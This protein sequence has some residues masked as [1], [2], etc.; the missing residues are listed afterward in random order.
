[1]LDK[2]SAVDSGFLG[3][4]ISALI[5]GLGG[6][7]DRLAERARGPAEFAGGMAGGDVVLDAEHLGAEFRLAA[8]RGRDPQDP[9]PAAAGW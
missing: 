2:P 5:R 9:G 1:M 6:V 7:E 4:T 3:R 8:Q